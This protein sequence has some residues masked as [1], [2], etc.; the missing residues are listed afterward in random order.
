MIAHCH[1]PNYN[2][3]GNAYYGNYLP[4]NE[5]G[6]EDFPSQLVASQHSELANE[7][8]SEDGDEIEALLIDAIRFRTRSPG[9]C[10]GA[11]ETSVSR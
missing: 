2:F 5:E 8:V 4:P 3:F 9:V 11:A 10:C 6:C 7:L 1:S